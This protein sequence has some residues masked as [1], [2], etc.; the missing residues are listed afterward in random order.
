M[1]MLSIIIGAV[2]KAFTFKKKPKDFELRVVE[3]LPSFQSVQQVHEFIEK[4][5]QMENAQLRGQ[6]SKALA[7]NERL[8][9]EKAQVNE[10]K[11]IKEAVYRQQ[12]ESQKLKAARRLKCKFILPYL[13]IFYLRNNKPFGKM[14]GFVF[15]ESTDGSTYYYPWIKVNKSERIINKPALTI[16]ALF[17]E[18]VGI[19]SQING[20]KV[21]SNYD[22][23]SDGQPVL[24][25][26][27]IKV[28]KDT[29]EKVKI[30]HLA[31]TEA[32]EYELKLGEYKAQYQKLANVLR[33]TQEEN[34]KLKHALGEAE[35][36]VETLNTQADLAAATVGNLT[37][38]QEGMA[39][40]VAD[41]TASLQSIKT[42]QVLTAQLADD[43]QDAWL[44][45]R[46]KY[47]DLLAED[48]KE[49][50]A[51]KIKDIVNLGVSHFIN[52]IQPAPARAPEKKGTPAK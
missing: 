34:E 5:H 48:D 22:I 41:N 13:P 52:R 47:R 29:D 42:E 8:R 43:L 49:V 23:T 4:K 26:P 20:G 38:Q 37:K 12:V 50:E 9:K 25:S 1:G 6:L 7:D 28:D 36:R 15:Q 51:Q 10:D 21:D 30:V 35:M 11:K 14:V 40:L 3:K 16:E 18:Q 45:M 39:K 2:K 46:S 19:V 27:N 44:K 32:R 24:R 31:D 17:K 33:D